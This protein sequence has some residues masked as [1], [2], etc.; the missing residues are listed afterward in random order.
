MKKAVASVIAVSSLIMLNSFKGM[1][2]AADTTI[3]DKE[4]RVVSFEDLSYP[5]IAHSANIQGVVVLRV[6]LDDQG[7]VLEAFPVSGAEPLISSVVANAKKWRFEPNPKRAAIL[8]YDFRIEGT[9]RDNT[10][11]GQSL[12]HW[13]NFTTIRACGKL[14]EP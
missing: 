5:A 8:V 14:V 6:T 2:S 9:C 10:E 11:S 3:Y 13:P 7:K 4:V 12:Y 1:S